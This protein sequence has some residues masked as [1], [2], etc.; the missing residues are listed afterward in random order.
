MRWWA[1]VLFIVAG[2]VGPIPKP[3]SLPHSI[4]SDSDEL[5]IVDGPLAL[6]PD[7]R[8]ADEVLAS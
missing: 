4:L 1:A 3:D 6:V 7:V 5:D 2:G 8:H